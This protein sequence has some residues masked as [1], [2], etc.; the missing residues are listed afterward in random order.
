M[1]DTTKTIRE[2]RYNGTAI[3]LLGGVDNP[4]VVTSD[5]EMEICLNDDRYL[6]MYVKFSGESENYLNGQVYKIAQEGE[7]S[8]FY[9]LPTLDN[10]GIAA[11]LAAG[12]QLIGSGG[13]VVTGTATIA[14]ENKL[15]QYADGT[16]TEV[17][18]EDLKGVSNISA[19]AFAFCKKLTS[20][21]IPDSVTSIGSGAF[22]ICSELSSITIGSG[23]TS[24]GS[25]AFS[26]CD[27][28]TTVYYTGDVA[29]WCKISGLDSGFMQNVTTLYINGQK[30]E[31]DLV[32]PDGVTSIPTCAFYN[33]TGLTSV[34]IPDSVTSIG[35]SAFNYCTGL[36]SVTIG[37]G[38]T[39]I[40]R[41]AFRNCG[42]IQNIYITDIAAWCNISGLYNLMDYGSSSKNLYLDN[43][44]VTSV[45]I[46]DGVT[47][48]PDDAFRGCTSLT[49]VTIPDSVTSIGS[50]A[51]YQCSGL[52]S[53]TIPDS[54]TSIGESA[55]SYCT[56]LTSITGSANNASKVARQ[57]TSIS[58]TSFAVTI[59]SGT[60][61]GDE[62]F[63]GCSG[64]TSITIPD[65]VTSI[66]A[67]A[68]SGCSG[69]TNVTIPDSVTSIGES[70]FNYCTGLTSITIP[71]S[72]T[73]IGSRVFYHC[74]GLTSVIIGNS[75]TSIG[76]EAFYQCSGLTS[77]II[78]NN[79]TS[80][81]SNAF[82]QCSGL[83]S[84]IIGNSVTS[85]G[86]QAF[87][88]CIVLTSVTI[89]DSVTKI[90]N[91]AFR[92]CYR[93]VEVYNKSA[94]SITAGN[95]SNGYVAYYAKN[96]Y[97]NEGGSKLT[98]DENGYVIYTDGDEKILIAYRG[99]NIELVL[100]SYITQINQYA[101]FAC[102]G[103]TSVTI[104]NS[105]TSIGYSAFSNCTGL[106]SI[107]IPD[108][109]I[110]I[111]ESA[112]SSCSL[113]SITI[114]DSVTSIGLHA[115]ESCGVLTSV[116]IGNGVT[117]IGNYT[118]YSCNSLADI[119]LLPTI[120][121]TL[122]SNVFYNIP[123]SVVITVPKGTLDAYQAAANW[124][125]YADK[126]VEASN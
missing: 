55:F 63:Y 118:F 49:S 120:P 41:D 85:I 125:T 103:L 52:T 40:G 53:I 101:F 115:F 46:S 29:G 108:S 119:T 11:D 54:V 28:L 33:C 83:T 45:T 114:P 89:P 7:V 43:E 122:G 77:V 31:G 57:T 14:T 37:N 95:S 9:Q 98:T 99:T 76:D 68:F 75:V 17:T 84:V 26:G 27:K 3:P 97:K 74:T 72:V 78:G 8:K 22:Y 116:T 87:Y 111:G 94:L 102:R 24:I 50:Q 21:T 88:Q 66:G 112:F 60:T 34:T 44:L 69:L 59:T 47:S 1:I 62:A 61:I 4:V 104:G 6:G 38:V 12:K 35:E 16:L 32:I 67:R 93:L 96:V 124:S 2:V 121:P 65:S 25:G 64:L 10:E 82:Y 92:Y 36:T 58:S 30:V 15:A 107:T 106:T 90:G 109:V 117:S 123:S 39:S 91:D 18:A 13:E 20:A 113:T 81:G 105:V 79:V 73:S 71:D 80:I 51:F 23:V 48:I 100:P 86:Y 42:K 110:S 5:A 126:M 56:G 19:Y 70:A